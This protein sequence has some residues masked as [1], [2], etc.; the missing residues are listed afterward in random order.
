MEHAKP[1][2]SE[3]SVGIADWVS[4]LRP[5]QWVKNVVV[6]AGPAAGMRL[7]DADG[8]IRAAVA[9]AAF[10]L[11]ASSAYAINDTL[12]RAADLSHPTK[13]FRPVARG[14]ISPAAA[15]V[16]ASALVVCALSI[17]TWLLNSQTTFILVAYF[18][19]TLAYS[20]ALKRRIILDVIIIATG[21]V[22]RAWGGS[23]AV[24]VATS[25]WLVACMFTLC[26]FLGFGKRRCEISMIP[27]AAEARQH[28]DILVRY[29]PDLLNHLITVSAGI[30][31]ITFLLYTLDS[32]PS[33]AP[34]GFQ[35]E[36]LF[37][38]LPLVMYGVFRYAMLTEL[39]AFT[40]PTEIILKDK[41]LLSSILMWAV[42]AMTIVYQTAIFGPEGLKPWLG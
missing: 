35:K 21:F 38:T 40:G 14:A 11:L 1:I 19:M 23:A 22:L 6:F 27:D 9:C 2:S 36:H 10:C 7:F 33:R 30:A 18:V 3:Q 5:M 28:R 39:G 12:D 16:C 25:E 37:Y 42:A 32:D 15:L 41:A 20:I 24:E 17:S 34:G 4:L 31:I 26:M 29:T 13:R 8:F